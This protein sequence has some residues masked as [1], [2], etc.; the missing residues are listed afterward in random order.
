MASA[1]Q[2]LVKELDKVFSLFIR[3]RASDENGYATCFTCGQVKKWKEGD[4]GHFISRGAYSTRWN[5]TNVQ[6]Q[7]KKCNIFQSGQQYLF[8]VALNRLH[9]E[10]TADALYVLSKQT[11]KYSTGELRA[12]IEIYKTKV[13]DIR[14]DKGLE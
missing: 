13:E 8:S 7:D 5:E 12:M 2:K 11:R 3:M 1:R 14:R 9:G 10:G 6:F 4:A